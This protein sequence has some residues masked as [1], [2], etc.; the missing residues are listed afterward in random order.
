MM[1]HFV[2]NQIDGHLSACGEK[3]TCILRF[4][5]CQWCFPPHVIFMPDND[6]IRMTELP[7]KTNKCTA[8]SS[9]MIVVYPCRNYEMK[10]KQYNTSVINL[11][12]M[13]SDVL[14]YVSNLYFRL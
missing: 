13:K 10:Q 9:Y 3:Y 2:V 6:S 14:I 7:N 1:L 8:D 11:S 12:F 4:D 5:G